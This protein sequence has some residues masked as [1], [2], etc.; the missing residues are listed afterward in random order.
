MVKAWSDWFDVETP[1]GRLLCR[2]RGRLRLQE[3]GLLVGD[4]VGVRPLGGGEG[5]IE[6]VKER[7]NALHRPPVANVDRVAVVSAWNLPAWNPH[8]VDRILVLAAA[9]G[10]GA[11]LVLNKVD[12]LAYE[13]REAM[14]A[15][16]RPYR[17]AGYPV[18][19]TSALTGEGLDELARC[20]AEG[21]TVFAGQSGVGKSHLLSRLTGRPLP[22]GEISARIGRGR[23]TTR[24]VELLPLPGGG[25]VADTP[26]FQ[27]LELVGLEPRDLGRYFPELAALAGDCRFR[28]CLHRNEPG[29][30][31]VDA[32]GRGEV[33]PG[34][35]ARYRE[36]L[37]EIESLK[38]QRY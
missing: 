9:E 19:E 7:R 34:R 22:T 13:E 8:L 37:A 3:G 35:Y 1:T 5:A 25:L 2:P 31:V 29:C 26:G 32:V 16:L 33:D 27:R 15:E 12:L 30:A 24:H 11:L 38:A 36:L 23:H 4:R 20:L 17:L 14:R 18:V 6:W 10:C 28:G 21:I